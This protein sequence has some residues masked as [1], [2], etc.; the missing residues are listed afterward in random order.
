MT[1]I[2]GFAELLLLRTVDPKMARDW[3]TSIHKDTLRMAKIVED[4]LDVSRI[5]SGRLV[6]TH[7][8][9]SLPEMVDRGIDSVRQSANGQ[10]LVNEV[11][12]ALPMVVID[13]DKLGQVLSNL[14][15]NAVKYSPP[16]STI[17]VSAHDAE[18]QRVVVCIDDQG[19][20]IAP[21]HVA[22]LFTTFYR[23]RRPETANVSGTGLGLYI[24]KALLELMGGEVWVESKVDQGTRL[25][26][27][28]PKSAVEADDGGEWLG[29]PRAG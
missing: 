19:I 2:M 4:M 16:A 17:T 25:Y 26:F 23:I 1:S 21:E 27:T 10:W 24:V 6:V 14:L 8:S 22:E 5:Q 15:D 20:G 3:V 29:L 28:L 11:T 12:A 9:V 7:E 18:R 13:P